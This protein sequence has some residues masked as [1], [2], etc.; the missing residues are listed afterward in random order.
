MPLLWL[1]LH[2]L[3]MSNEHHQSASL[4]LLMER[5]KCI[6]PNY[7]MYLSKLIIVFV[8]IAMCNEHHQSGS[9]SLPL[10][11]ARG[12]F[13][14]CN[15]LKCILSRVYFLTK[16]KQP[17]F[18]SFL[19]RLAMSTTNKAA[20]SSS[21]K[22]SGVIR[23]SFTYLSSLH[24]CHWHGARWEIQDRMRII[25]FQNCKILP[26]GWSK[27]ITVFWIAYLIFQCKSSK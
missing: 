9:L 13:Q 19:H 12:I 16:K 17:V 21:G 23:I 5:A 3:P 18:A 4:S 14:N 11:R 10:E 25:W 24:A 27:N 20:V 22:I 1:F 2:P 8:Q 15:F 6:F 7:K 26:V